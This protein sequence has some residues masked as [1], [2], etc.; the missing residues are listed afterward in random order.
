MSWIIKFCVPRSFFQTWLAIDLVKARS[1][2]LQ[3]I[4]VVVRH[5][6]TKTYILKAIVY[7]FAVLIHFIDRFKDMDI[8]FKNILMNITL[9]GLLYVKLILNRHP[10]QNVKFYFH[11]KVRVSLRFWKGR[12]WWIRHYFLWSRKIFVICHKLITF[13]FASRNGFAY[14]LN[15]NIMVRLLF[16]VRKL[17]DKFI[18]M[19]E[20]CSTMEKY[21]W[22]HKSATISF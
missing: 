3:S 13:C 19:F 16:G 20:W 17:A 21:I 14:V 7:W 4:Q 18:Q 2:T 12:L 22:Y 1:C 6:G 15:K 11:I 10:K 5:C 9:F 8:N